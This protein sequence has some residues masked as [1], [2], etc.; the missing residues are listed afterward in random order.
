MQISLYKPGP[1]SAMGK[2]VVSQHL[3]LVRYKPFFGFKNKFVGGREKFPLKGSKTRNF[4]SLYWPGENGGSGQI[5]RNLWLHTDSH[6]FV[7]YL[8]S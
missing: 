4:Q 8:V 1:G 2:S 3:D 5:L 6:I 7:G